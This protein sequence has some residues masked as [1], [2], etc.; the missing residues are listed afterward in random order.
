MVGGSAARPLRRCRRCLRSCRGRADGQDAA[1]G[2][3][4]AVIADGTVEV[5]GRRSPAPG[6]ERTASGRARSSSTQPDRPFIARGDCSSQR[7]GHRAGSRRR[8]QNLRQRQHPRDA[9]A[10]GRSLVDH[11]DKARVLSA[12]RRTVA[13]CSCSRSPLRTQRRALSRACIT[14]RTST[15]RREPDRRGSGRSG[16]ETVVGCHGQ[17]PAG[18]RAS[19][20]GRVEARLWAVQFKGV[21]MDDRAPSARGGGTCRRDLRRHQRRKQGRG[22][23]G[24]G[25]RSSVLSGRATVGRRAGRWRPGA[26]GGCAG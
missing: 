11:Q 5:S 14:E 20:G 21:R 15:S 9:G 2:A 7:P 19:E 4:A 3:E 12:Y 22:V 16:G 13:S 10:A 18:G 8:V 24:R 6:A 23:L 26:S 17:R 1:G 25:G